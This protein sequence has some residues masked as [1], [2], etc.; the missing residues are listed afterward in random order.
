MSRVR[1]HC[2]ACL[3][4]VRVPVLSEQMAVAPPMVSHA[5]RTRTKLLSFIILRMEY[6][7]TP[8]D[9]LS[10]SPPGFLRAAICGVLHGRTCTA[11]KQA[12]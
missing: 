6:A 2:Q 5:A 12:P 9:Q 7:C 11:H 1:M 3:F 10:G 4:S 8:P